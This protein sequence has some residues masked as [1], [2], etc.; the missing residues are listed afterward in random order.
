MSHVRRLHRSAWLAFAVVIVLALSGCGASDGA[1][2]RSSAEPAG[3]GAPPL[4][5]GAPTPAEQ[6][7]D[8]RRARRAGQARLR[9]V[10]RVGAGAGAP[11]ARNGRH[12]GLRARA[13]QAIESSLKLAPGNFEALKMRT[14]VLLGKHEFAAALELARSAQQK[15][16]GRLARLRL[17]YRRQRRARPLQG[18]RGG[19]SVDARLATRQHP[20][21]H[22]CGVLCASCSAISRGRSN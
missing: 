15:G 21:V 13:E 18:R 12:A 17:S 10:Q 7:I 11:C 6:R 20:G 5:G 3:Y 2:H 14:W 9:C 4:A 16:A 8:C 22:A 19:L 1:G